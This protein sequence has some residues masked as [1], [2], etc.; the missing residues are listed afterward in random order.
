MAMPARVLIVDDDADNREL[1]VRMAVRQ[2]LDVALAEDGDRALAI[3]R[4]EPVD[5]ILLDI[6]MPRLSGLQVLE[7]LKQDAET[8]HV[9]VIVISALDEREHIRACIALGAE[10]Y[11]TRPFDAA[12]LRVRIDASLQ[13]KRLH[14]QAEQARRGLERSAEALG[15]RVEEATA[16]LQRRLRELSGMIDVAHA[17]ISTLDLDS[18]LAGVMQLSR[19]VMS[20]EASSLLVAD[21]EQRLL[22]FHVATGTAGK[23]I[24]GGTIPYGRGIAGY[25]AETGE[26][27]LIPDAYQDPRFDP[28][29]DRATGFRTRSILT[30]PL[31]TSEGIAG[32]LQVVNKIGQDAFD[33]HDLDL[34][35][36]FA[37]MAGISLQN[38]RL[39]ER[40]RNVSDD[41]RVALERERWLAIERE[42]LGAYLPKS[43]V[44]QI[45]RD[46]E[47][48]LALG[49]KTVTAT[50]LFA[51]IQAFTSLSERLAPQDVV[52]F[53]NEYMTAMTQTL[54]AEGGIVDKFIGDGIMAIFL[55][56]DG[57]DNHALRAVRAG[58]AMQARV[59]ELKADWRL[60]RPDVAGLA[61]RI[62][63]NTGEMVAGN[64]GSETRM[65][66]TV[67]GDNVNLAARIEAAGQGGEV[68]VSEAVHRRVADHVRARALGSIA[69]K[70]RV[71]PVAVY[72][73]TGLIPP[74]GD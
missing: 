27:L 24:T 34:F 26:S 43:V 37:G 41:L 59:A 70:N 7:R 9:P 73:V 47:Q 36:S 10:D 33:Q 63:I 4:S 62:G 16:T 72:T 13:R 52:A 57:T 42:K 23:A 64:I 54:E 3:A 68:H 53:L 14:D 38:A 28:S 51:D 61:A 32:V 46:R 12:L 29:Y 60:R 5:L 44:D 74:P 67:I 56:H 35:Q 39:F 65:D 45:S 55:P 49:G 48:K 50:V 30:V 58:L 17:I 2:G 20:A 69:V 8:R 19:E 40:L 1:L 31:R 22:R 66:Y 18:L 25:V 6:V 11:L 21:P 15:A 71:E